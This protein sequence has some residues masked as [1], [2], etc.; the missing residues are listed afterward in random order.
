MNVDYVK[1][2]TIYECIV[3]SQ[4]YG[5]NNS[6]SDIDEAG[7]MIP[8]KEFF[9][10]FDHFNQFDG[11]PN[12]DKTI[13][14]IRKILK[15]IADNNPNC[16]DL[17]FVPERCIK[18]ITPYW[19]KILENRDL[20]VS[21][22]ARWTYAGYAHA[23]FERILVHRKFLLHPLKKEPVRS[24]FGLPD[25]SRF[26]TAQLKAVVYATLGDFL[27]EE[28]KENFLD[29]LDDV[30]SNYVIPLFTR[31]IREDR[32]TLALEYLQVGIKSQANTL[33][34][35]GPSYIKE[36]FL[37]EA[38]RELQYYTAK[39]EWDRFMDWQKH[40][41][42]ARAEM[43]AKFGYDCKHAMHLIRLARMCM[44]ILKTGEVHV[45]R[46]GIDA[47]ELI[48]IRDGAWSFDKVREY[49]EKIDSE[50]DIFYNESKIQRAPDINK[51]KA[52]CV[53]ICEEYLWKKKTTFDVLTT[54]LHA[55]KE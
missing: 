10:G 52:L 14:D 6:H 49:S 39:Q 34:A 30:Y 15:L 20:F 41:N 2:H 16:I 32:R 46:T 23:Q 36:E 38:T 29:Q 18:T 7:V 42:K 51:I 33:R 37:D 53:E 40:R 24:E 5:T 21:K 3:G 47:D 9:L 28:E 8:G 35:L 1:E 12:K 13:Y 31:Y 22:K 25:V 27:V 48:A 17:L 19:E 50:A 26:P 4:A 55:S 11:Y 44:E 45:D 43:E 54:L